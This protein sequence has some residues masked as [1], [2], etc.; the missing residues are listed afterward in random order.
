LLETSEAQAQAVWTDVHTKVDIAKGGGQVQSFSAH[1][2]PENQPWSGRG[3]W[4]R[5]GDFSAVLKTGRARAQTYG[6]HGSKGV[7]S[8]GLK[9]AGT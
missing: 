3:Q 1:L 6:V 2:Q 7:L 9:A 8:V 5:E 4:V